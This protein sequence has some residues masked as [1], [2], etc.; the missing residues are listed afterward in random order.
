MSLAVVGLA[1][2]IVALWKQQA[3]LARIR[4]DFGRLQEQDE[5]LR[6]DLKQ[7]GVEPGRPVVTGA[8]GQG[9]AAPEAHQGAA[10]PQVAA[11]LPVPG[12]NRL[13]LAGTAV[14]AIPGGLVATLK[15]SPSKAG[16]FGQV[17]LAARLPRNAEARI[18]D[19]GPVGPA[20]YADDSKTVSEDGKFAFFQGMLGAETNVQFSLSVSG[21]VTVD[22]HGA[23]GIGAFQLDIQ[24]T[25][26]AVRTK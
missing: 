5:G 20:T 18:L 11:H 23:R 16:P 2:V 12:A 15:Y 7:A 25:G 22:V 8:Q 6:R 17:A 9:S 14:Q 19:V 26:A 4:R 24:P 21:P 1:V 3:D 13:V 10:V